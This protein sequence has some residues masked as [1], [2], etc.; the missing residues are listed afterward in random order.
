[1][2]N[3]DEL[4]SR[5]GIDSQVSFKQLPDG[6]VVAEID[7]VFATASMS[8]YGGHIVSWQPKSQ[9]KPVLWVS[10]LVKFQR[11]KAIRGGVPICWPWFGAHPTNASLPGHGYARITSWELTSVQ[12]LSNGAT[13]LNL[14]RR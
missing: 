11:G 1:M 7:N 3:T 8:L 9:S 5:F 14:R 13:E 10:K 12:T 4:N 2:K 6:I